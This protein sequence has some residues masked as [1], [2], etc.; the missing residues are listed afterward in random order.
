MSED[1]DNRSISGLVLFVQFFFAWIIK[2]FI[3]FASKTQKLKSKS[4]L[5]SDYLFNTAY[6][7]GRYIISFVLFFLFNAQV[8]AQEFTGEPTK[9]SHSEITSDQ[10]IFSE[11]AVV[12][13]VSKTDFKDETRG[14]SKTAVKKQK[15]AVKKE[16]AIE[17]VKPKKVEIELPVNPKSYQD[18]PLQQS[19]SFVMSL[20]AKAAGGITVQQIFA[21]L[22]L[23][24]VL[25]GVSNLHYQRIN[26]ALISAIAFRFNRR[27]TCRPPPFLA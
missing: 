24:R 22:P 2:V 21:V 17:K 11:G 20:T 10:I 4:T 12:I 8:H 5:F 3:I 26:S 23:H 1:W 9:T 14:P 13:D 19:Q 6:L 25:I 16:K 15:I 7:F 27:F 18:F